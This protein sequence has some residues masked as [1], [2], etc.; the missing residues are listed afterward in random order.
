LSTGDHKVWKKS[1]KAMMV[2]MGLSTSSNPKAA[3][4]SRLP[5]H[6]EKK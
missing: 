5:K 1:N 2:G 6:K 4:R 3:A